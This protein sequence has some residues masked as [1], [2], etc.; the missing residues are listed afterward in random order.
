M[1]EF[2]VAAGLREDVNA[3]KDAGGNLN[4][5]YSATDSSEVSSLTT[6]M[7][8]ISQEKAIKR[9]LTAYME[10]VSKDAKDMLAFISTAEQMDEQI[11]ASSFLS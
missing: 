1:A 5:S 2:K 8:Y 6:C 7:A 11:A 9:L 3:V 4:A 10:L